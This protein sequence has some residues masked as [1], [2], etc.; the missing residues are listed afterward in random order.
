M[1]FAKPINRRYQRAR[2]HAIYSLSSRLTVSRRREF[3]YR[4]HCLPRRLALNSRHSRRHAHKSRRVTDAD[5][6]SLIRRAGHLLFE[7]RRCLSSGI[8]KMP[9]SAMKNTELV[10]GHER[11]RP[12]PILEAGRSSA[13]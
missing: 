13:S 12:A 5:F 10:A 11:R 3:I 2:H 8:G 7:A 9:L 6:L 4:E 1:I